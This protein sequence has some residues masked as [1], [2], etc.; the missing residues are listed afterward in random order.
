MTHLSARAFAATGEAPKHLSH[1]GVATAQ[2][3]APLC[4]DVPEDVV[5]DV[6][7]EGVGARLLIAWHG[8]FEVGLQTV[9]V[10]HVE[11]LS[12]EMK[13]PAR[14]VPHEG[15]ARHG[16][17]DRVVG[18]QITSLDHRGSPFTREHPDGQ[19]AVGLDV[20]RV[21]QVRPRP[22][23]QFLPRPPGEGAERVVC[24]RAGSGRAR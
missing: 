1:Y 21:H 15:D 2:A 17:H 19:F 22:S 13:R 24:A 12:D 10:G 3:L 7:T 20:V 8:L 11:D 18:S 16:V 4:D 9:P 14:L 23:V 5:A 6:V